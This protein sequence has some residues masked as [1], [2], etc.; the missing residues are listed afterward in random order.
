M[1]NKKGFTLIELLAVIAILAL[2][3]VIA[4][5]SVI[6]VSNLIKG[7]MY[8]AK[9]KLIEEAAKQYGED[10]GSDT[11]VSVSQLC[12]GG[13]LTKDKNA[14]G[15]TCMLNPKTNVTMDGCV[16]NLTK[17]NSRIKATYNT[18]DVSGYDCD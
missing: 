12:T 7:K 10:N 16:V 18:G 14:S 5:P 8:N 1:K 13:Y 3:A 17:S 11:S 4:V 2:I 6:G 15:T 9:I